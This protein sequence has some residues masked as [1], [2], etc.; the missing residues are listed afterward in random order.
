MGQE[1][2]GGSFFPPIF[3]MGVDF[4][5][6][7]DSP[8]EKRENL[9]HLH[10]LRNNHAQ[11]SVCSGGWFSRQFL[12]FR[13]AP[14]Q[15]RPT[16]GGDW[17]F[18]SDEGFAAPDHDAVSPTD[19]RSER[20]ALGARPTAGRARFLALK[21]SSLACRPPRTPPDA[22]LAWPLGA[23]VRILGGRAGN[24]GD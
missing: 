1:G 2:E 19:L 23:G 8:A 21:L 4:A 7:R 14:R 5:L 6:G 24:W 13:G 18:R 22:C 9:L 16:G 15:A 10:A 17:D 12:T 3:W 11:H 20:P